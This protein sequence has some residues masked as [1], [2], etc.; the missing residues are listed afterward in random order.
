LVKIACYVESYNFSDPQE[1]QALLKFKKTAE[2]MKHEFD[3]LW[4]QNLGDIPH[5]NSLFIRATTDPLYTAYI[6]S[7]IGWENG[8]KV[9]DTPHSIKV[10]SNKIHMYR[11]LE[12]NNIPLIPTV[13][14]T[15]EQLHHRFI[16]EAFKKLGC[17][18]VVKA[19]YT[20]F[21]K[22]VEKVRCETSFRNVCKRFF[23]KSDIVVLQKF[24]PTLFDWRVG[25]LNEEILYVCRYVMPKGKWKHGMKLRGK[26][27][28]I[29][30]RTTSISR[31][32]APEKLKEVALKACKA[33][34]NNDLFGVDI[35]EVDGHYYVVEVND[36][37][38]IYSGYE[39]AKDKDIYQKIIEALTD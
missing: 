26:S 32:A 4:K 18:L 7:K 37:P 15:K 6:V 11:L 24:V 20:S 23:R 16:E 25:V 14:L 1:M 3:F 39:D 10:C 5:Y 35:K 31:Y 29:W 2:K 38:S 9:L 22:Y 27:K 34:G 19:P 28:F 13:I 30:G 36:N 8:L 17:P 33:I 12:R 21:S